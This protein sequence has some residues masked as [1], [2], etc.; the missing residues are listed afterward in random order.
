LGD[1][2]DTDLKFGVKLSPCQHINMLCSESNFATLQCS[3]KNLF[4]YEYFFKDTTRS[5]GDGEIDGQDYNFIS[6]AQ[7]EEYVG[8][9]Y[10]VE[11][12]EY[13]KSYYGTSLDSIRYKQ[14]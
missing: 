4:F 6:R 13:E 10:F 9:S 1:I 5:K 3:K 2:H 12:G 8:K 14:Y 7:F 11:H